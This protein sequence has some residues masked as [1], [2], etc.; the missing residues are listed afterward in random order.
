MLGRE[1]KLPGPSLHL[2]VL[3]LKQRFSAF[4]RDGGGTTRACENLMRETDADPRNCT[5]MPILLWGVVTPRWRPWSKSPVP[6]SAESHCGGCPRNPQSG[7]WGTI[8]SSSWAK[9]KS[10]RQTC[11]RHQSTGSTCHLHHRTVL[12][13]GRPGPTRGTGRESTLACT[14]PSTIAQR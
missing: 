6:I 10:N 9:K 7:L 3:T 11:E 2:N 5:E 8:R 14:P 4:W 13:T 12:R 1:R